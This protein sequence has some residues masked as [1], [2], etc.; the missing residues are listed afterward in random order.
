MR[1]LAIE[2]SCDETAIAV[3]ENENDILVN[4]V[5]SQVDVHRE[6]GGVV[7]EIAA[8]HHVE[9]MKYLL[10][11]TF[12]KVSPNS[13]D[14]IAVTQGPGLVGALLVGI[15]VAK[16][17]AMALNLPLVGVN[18]LL[19]HIYSVYLA[20]PDLKPPF[21][22]L[23]ASGGHTEIVLVR[24]SGVKVLGKT[25]DDAAGEA[26]DKVAR[27]LKLG[28][29]GG[30]AIEKASRE[31][32]IV[33]DFPRPKIDSDDLNFSFSGL[34]TAVLYFV[35][36]NRNFRVE[37]VAASFQEAV[38]DVLIEKVFRAALLNGIRK[39]AFVGGVSANTRLRKR[40]LERAQKWN[41]EVY[42]PPL[43]F[44]TD[45]A[46]MIARAAFDLYEKGVISDMSMNAVPYLTL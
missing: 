37:D 13:L 12:K 17:L 39:I 6:F 30:P 45:N 4:L 24:E 1:I 16:G 40:A 27:I 26:F 3:L 38:I 32:E 43:E 10:D 7:P 19:G 20:F 25:L 21:I 11:T 46:V 2:T 14:V 44:S 33:Y 15:S 28:Y 41:Y 42:F 23:I 31:G 35:R 9:N 29:P 22:A 8:R 36:R 34:K 18:H 5:A